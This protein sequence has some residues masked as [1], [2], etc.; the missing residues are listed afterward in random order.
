M[1]FIEKNWGFFLDFYVV[2]RPMVFNK[3][4]AEKLRVFEFLLNFFHDFKNLEN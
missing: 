4:F 3:K 1:G 2:D